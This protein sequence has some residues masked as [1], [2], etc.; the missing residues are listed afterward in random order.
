MK[1]LTFAIGLL[2]V[3]CLLVPALLLIGGCSRSGAQQSSGQQ[4]SA[5]SDAPLKDIVPVDALPSNPG[6][7]PASQYAYDDL[8]KPVAFEILLTNNG[9]VSSQQDPI[10]AYLGKKYNATIK[11]S[12]ISPSDLETVVST[13]FAAQDYPDVMVIGA[14]SR[15]ITQLLY[16]NGQ[17]IDA[18]KAMVYMPNLARYFTKDYDQFISYKG[19]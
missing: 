9:V 12:S 16:D 5:Y 2:G 1:K 11:T 15:Q 13:R 8:S 10:A 14:G 6:P 19:A 4:A 7:I 18:K 17:L 3:F